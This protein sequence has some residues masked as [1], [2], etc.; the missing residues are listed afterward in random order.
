MSKCAKN[1]FNSFQGRCPALRLGSIRRVVG[2]G[3]GDR[4]KSN[5]STP[6]AFVDGP[7]APASLLEVAG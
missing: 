5:Q 3:P 1:V 2:R 4:S 7:S 6:H